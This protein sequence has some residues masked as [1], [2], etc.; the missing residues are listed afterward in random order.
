MENFSTVV[1]FMTACFLLLELIELDRSSLNTCGTFHE[2]FCLGLLLWDV[3]T[4][5]MGQMSTREETY[6][7]TSVS[8]SQ[9]RVKTYVT[10]GCH[11]LKT[12]APIFPSNKLIELCPYIYPIHD[13][14]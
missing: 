2:Y 3:A 12:F 9:E 11:R 10:N 7:L 1:N 14:T 6:A 8:F 5:L 4:I 13:G